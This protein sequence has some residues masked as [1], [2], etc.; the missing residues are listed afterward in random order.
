MESQQENMDALAAAI[1]GA[2]L[3]AQSTLALT[4]MQL[5]I[6]DER[7]R[8]FEA[9]VA[10]YERALQLTQNKLEAGVVGKS[11]V[12]VATTQLESTRAQLIDT[13][14]QRAVLENAIAVLLGVPPSQFSLPPTQFAIKSPE[15][16]VVLPAELL[17][18]R[19]AD[20]D[21]TITSTGS[22]FPHSSG[23]WARF[24]RKPFSTV[25]RA[26]R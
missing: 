5:R 13:Q 6:V 7:T 12:A 14:Q 8:V 22:G 15:V 11:D 18:L 25:A 20:I 17:Q 23:R 1:G 21:P 24:L 4:Y 26:R 10:S 2:R 3:T 9:A 19:R 16:P